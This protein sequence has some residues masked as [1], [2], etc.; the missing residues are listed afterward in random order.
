MLALLTTTLLAITSLIMV[1]FGLN[2]GLGGFVTLGLQ[3][4]SAQATAPD[5]T[6]FARHD[7][8]VRFLGG[9]FAGLGG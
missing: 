4:P 9:V 6:A 1:A 7:S 8:N 2:I 5:P 3:F